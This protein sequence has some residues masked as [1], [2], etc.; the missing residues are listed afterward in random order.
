M[1]KLEASMSEPWEVCKKSEDV[2]WNIRLENL[3][4]SKEYT[5]SVEDFFSIM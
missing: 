3:K 4:L 5:K 2:L 1:Q